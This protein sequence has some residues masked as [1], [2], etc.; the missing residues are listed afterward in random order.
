[1][2]VQ[3][4]TVHKNAKIFPEDTN[5]FVTKDIAETGGLQADAQ[6]LE[7]SLTFCFICYNY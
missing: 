2:S 1:M 3:E 5:A 4:T 7:I 6:V